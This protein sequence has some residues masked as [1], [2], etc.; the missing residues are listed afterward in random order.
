MSRTTVS[1]AYNR[2]GQLSG[3]LRQRILA[4]AADLGYPGPDPVARGLRRGRTGVVGLVYDQPLSY[5]FTDPA[6]GLFITGMT[7]VWEEAGVALALLPRLHADD[8]G[9]AVLARAAVDGFV[10][11]CDV[12]D[13]ARVR[14]LVARR[15][16]FVMV[17]GGPS[18][19]ACR[20]DI[21]D[22]GA[23][24]EATRHLLA[25]GHRRLAVAALQAGPGHPGGVVD[26]ATEKTIRYTLMAARLAGIRDAVE[27]AGLGSEALPVM[28]VP[29]DPWPRAA[30][31]V[32][33]GRLLDRAERPTGVVA[34][35]DE[36]AAGVIDAAAER[37]MS[38]PGDLSVVGFD[39]T[40]TAAGTVPPLTTIHQP[41]GAKGEAAARL[42]LE[43]APARVVELPTELV[44]RASTGPAPAE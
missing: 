30:G 19:A 21:D 18:G 34:M 6:A 25:L 39:D 28:A 3:A 27:A 42:L 40:P 24:R 37:G 38:V 26:A 29:D 16:P 20:V 13:D 9:V 14:A 1:N 2:P 23:S 22:R 41:H 17:D 8:D 36:V 32:L 11:Y 33:G 4:V 5:I 44:V 7:S 43:G 15:L 35:S 12:A 31:R 10:V